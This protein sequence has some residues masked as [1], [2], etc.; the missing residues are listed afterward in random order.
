M[1]AVNRESKIA[2][3]DM[4]LERDSERN[5]VSSA[6]DTSATSAYFMCDLLGGSPSNVAMACLG[7]ADCE[8]LIGLSMPMLIQVIQA[9]DD[10]EDAETLADAAA[11]AARDGVVHLNRKLIRK[12]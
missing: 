5:P 11:D 6:A 3:W 12:G 9:I 2:S 4:R 10:D 8:L 1:T 7:Q